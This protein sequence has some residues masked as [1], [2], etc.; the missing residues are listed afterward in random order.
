MTDTKAQFPQ[1][2]KPVFIGEFKNDHEANEI[3]P[4]RSNIRYLHEP[5]VQQKRVYF[6]LSHG[7]ETFRAKPSDGRIDGLLKYIMSI[8]A[9][10]SNLQKNIHD[11]QFVTWRGNCKDEFKK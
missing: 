3:Q 4:G 9:P 6:D 7:F 1:I 11:C 5:L 2:S 8:S 10:G